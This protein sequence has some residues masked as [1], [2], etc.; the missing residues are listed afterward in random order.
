MSDSIVEGCPQGLTGASPAEREVNDTGAVV[1]R[2]YDAGCHIRYRAAAIG[3]LDADGHDAAPRADAGDAGAV[4]GRSG[5]DP[6]H[7][8]P[9]PELVLRAAE[10]TG[11]AYDLALEVR[12]GRIDPGI[13]DGDDYGRIALGDVPSG[14][15]GDGLRGPLGDVAESCRGVNAGVV[16]IVWTE[17]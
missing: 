13:Y 1:R 2:V 15:R 5:R 17:L 10:E 8:S 6:C 9:M 11:A 16:R 12:M 7:V 3:I 4:V 14:R